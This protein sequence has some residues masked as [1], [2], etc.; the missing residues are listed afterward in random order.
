MGSPKSGVGVVSVHSPIR[1][2]YTVVRVSR[3]SQGSVQSQLRASTVGRH[4]AGLDGSMGGE[5]SPQLVNVD[6]RTS[7][8][9]S[10]SL[11]RSDTTP[12]GSHADI[13]RST[14]RLAEANARSRL[15]IINIV[16]S[17]ANG[18]AEVMK[19]DFCRLSSVSLLSV[20]ERRLPWPNQYIRLESGRSALDPLEIPFSIA[21]AV[22]EMRTVTS[23]R[24]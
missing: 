23:E 16:L 13:N 21:D 10:R 8:P 15:E 5:V 11:P 6:A 18:R 4:R 17:I 9:R 12:S 7:E 22:W 24:R 19:S 3:Y 20:V 14:F 1:Y 2:R